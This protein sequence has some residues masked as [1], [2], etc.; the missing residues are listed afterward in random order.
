MR[1]IQ[2][3]NAKASHKIKQVLREERGSKI[4]ALKGN[5]DRPTDKPTNQ[6]TDRRLAE[7]S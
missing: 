6:P 3:N 7:G 1:L 5:Y 4:S 2:R